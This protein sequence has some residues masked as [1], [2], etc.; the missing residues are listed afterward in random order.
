M[1]SWPAALRPRWTTGDNSH[2]TA[3]S[4]VL[5]GR[6]Y[7]IELLSNAIK[8]LMSKKSAKTNFFTWMCVVVPLA[9][10]HIRQLI[11]NFWCRPAGPAVECFELVHC[12]G[13]GI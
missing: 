7:R 4:A 10:D 9:H 12:V 3:E 5:T 1:T 13:V 8:L 6:I 11:I 2:S